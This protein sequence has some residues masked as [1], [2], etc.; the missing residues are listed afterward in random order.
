MLAAR[1]PTE[2]LFSVVIL[3][4]ILASD[5]PLLAGIARVGS[6]RTR[7]TLSGVRVVTVPSPDGRMGAGGDFVLL[8]S[9]VAARTEFS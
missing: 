7:S 3:E 5:A 1:Q 2:V 4:N 6:F 9:S 8:A